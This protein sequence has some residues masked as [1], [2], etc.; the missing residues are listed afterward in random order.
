MLE[1]ITIA[2]EAT[3]D[4]NPIELDGL[5]QFNYFFGS[6]GAGKTTISRVL[7]N[8]SKFPHCS[9][10]WR[11]GTPLETIV[12]NRDFVFANFHECEELPG[13]FTLGEQNTD[14]IKRIDQTRAELDK[15][16]E[17]LSQLTLT[18]Q[19]PDGN[20]GKR[21]ELA[22]IE[23]SLKDACWAQKQK[24]DAKLK[25]AFEG[26]RHSQEKFKAK[27]LQEHD[28]NKAKKCD[29]ADL[30][31][32]AETVFGPSPALA[33][34]I[35]QIDFSALI[36]Y[37]NA[38]ILKKRIV[39]KSDVD[40]ASLIIKLGN[41][42]WV[43]AGRIFYRSEERICPFCQQKTAE[44]LESSLNEYFDERF[45]KESS[46]IAD[47][48]RAYAQEASRVQQD[49]VALI[50]STSRNID[51]ERLRE[52]K[53]QLDGVL[54]MNAQKL[55]LKAKSPSESVSLDSITVTSNR[56]KEVLDSAITKTESHNKLV[57]G[58]AKA[59][60]DLTAEVWRYLLDVE[61]SSNLET[62]YA[63]KIA[64]NAAI[65]KL[66]EGISGQRLLIKGKKE[67][68]EALEKSTT[69]VQ[70]TIDGI[71]RFLSTF[72]FQGF[73]LTASDNPL[74]YKMVRPDGAD[75]KQTLSEGERT[76][77]TFLYFLHLLKGSSSASGMSTN[78]VVV[79]DDPVSSLDSDILFIVGSL[80]KGVLE[81]VRCDT[82]QIKQVF[83]LTHNVYFHK[84]VTFN[85]NRKDISMREETFW[86]VR[87]VNGK[88]TIEK[89]NSNPIKT[90]YELLWAEVRRTDRPSIAIQNTLRRILENYF[91]ILGGVDPDS[92]CNKFD[93]KDRL[94]CRSLFSW[95]NDG[96]HSAHDDLYVSA[97][98]SEVQVY[99]RVFREIFVRTDHLP[100][101]QMMMGDTKMEDSVADASVNGT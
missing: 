24:H 42:D 12:Y 23:Y 84:E 62:Y 44:S 92:I 93:G 54:R 100:H 47:I 5:S 55:E 37:E 65:Q 35:D 77:V 41:S 97:P 51:I 43:K 10:N 80:I 75:A 48:K 6:N 98:D 79:I 27:V 9:L 64:V 96:S 25:G 87:K 58:L 68:L 76:F 14:T 67:E 45:V 85:P 59:R 31:K 56:I 32:R 53:E 70:P 33:P 71:N 17:K 38:E 26:W 86:I 91:R 50:E 8:C 90:S 15:L 34:T 3:F 2:A 11:R 66:E 61:L 46:E 18:L 57:N 94:V 81:E 60:S 16:N 72:G 7:A 82:S 21:L 1:K 83:L 22:L 88:S 95:I 99:L 4:K 52:L 69:S 19:G 63:K 89:H 49:L 39:G 36:E 13:I 20:G 78:R 29:L 101:Y 40:I 74:C 28:S 73:R 30:E